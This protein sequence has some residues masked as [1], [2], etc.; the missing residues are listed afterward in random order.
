MTVLRAVLFG[1]VI[2]QRLVWD[3]LGLGFRVQDLGFRVWDLGIWV[4]QLDRSD[5]IV[6]YSCLYYPYYRLLLGGGRNQGRIA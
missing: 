6:V 1:F 5:T 3:Y 4:Q 2:H